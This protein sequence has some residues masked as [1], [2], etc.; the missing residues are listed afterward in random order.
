MSLTKK[1]HRTCTVRSY[2]DLPPKKVNWIDRTL[3]STAK[4]F[5]SMGINYSIIRSHYTSDYWKPGALVL[6]F[7]HIPGLLFPKKVM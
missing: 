7:N 3:H 2:Y 6:F 5:S 1:Y 4:I